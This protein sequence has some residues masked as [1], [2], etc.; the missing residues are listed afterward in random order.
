MKKVFFILVMSGIFITPQ[1]VSAQFL[2]NLG[3]VLETVGKT[4]ISDE[5]PNINTVN[6]VTTEDGVTV[7]NN[8]PGF[9][10]EYQGVTWQKDFCGVNFLI[11]NKG[12]Q[13]VRVYS[14]EKM[15]TF[16]IQ[17]KE[18]SARSIVGQNVT[19]LGN[20][21]FDF[22]PGVPVKCIYA[23][24]DLPVT[25]TKINLCQLRVQTHDATKGYEDR[26]IE[27]RNVPIPSKPIATVSG[28]FKG[29][30]TLQ[31]NNAEGKLTLDLYNKSVT[32]MTFDGD[33][34]KC[35]GTIYI[36]MTVGLSV[37]IDECLITECQPNGNKATVKFVGGRDGNTY[38]AILTYNPTTKKITVSDCQRLGDEE[39]GECYV[40]DGLVF[41]K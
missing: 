38:Q 9:T 41:S 16:D 37:R 32:G 21:D 3:K 27:F 31:S 24:F 36:G 39:F 26:F 7:I 29:T 2:K 20:G 5:S 8:L 19:S 13:K 10:V 30:W 4:L 23:I 14:F 33:G 40:T 17:G 6:T 12:N 22:E 34:V 35:Y 18:Y 15:K 28:P 1:K 11:T 25:G